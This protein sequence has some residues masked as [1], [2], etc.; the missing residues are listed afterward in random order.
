MSNIQVAIL[1]TFHKLSAFDNGVEITL[2]LTEAANASADVRLVR[3]FLAGITF[4]G[5]ARL[6]FGSFLR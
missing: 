4:D 1:Q 2:N 5:S 3:Q 6:E